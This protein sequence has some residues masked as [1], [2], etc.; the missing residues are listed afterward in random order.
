MSNRLP[1]ADG[2]GNPSNCNQMHTDPNWMQSQSTRAG[3]TGKLDVHSSCKS[4]CCCLLRSNERITAMANPLTK[5]LSSAEMGT[6]NG[7]CLL[8]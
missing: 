7:T 6:W 5:Q 2:T 1:P 8:V 3:Q 4:Q